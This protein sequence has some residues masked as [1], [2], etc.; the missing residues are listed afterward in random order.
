MRGGRVSTLAKP[1]RKGIRILEHVNTN[2]PTMA[3]ADGLFLLCVWTSTTSP[4]R[5][6]PL[7]LVIGTRG[8]KTAVLHLNPITIKGLR[9]DDMKPHFDICLQMA[10]ILL[11]GIVLL[12]G[13]QKP[14]E[15]SPFSME[16]LDASGT[17]SL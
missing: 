12:T 15:R 5:A 16:V 10:G 7:H 3:M 11:S 17:Q 8:R 1:L 14:R 13:C 6:R 2:A 9:L 4:G